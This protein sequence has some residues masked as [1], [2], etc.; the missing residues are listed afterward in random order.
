MAALSDPDRFDIWAEWMR[1][2]RETVAISKTDLRAA[3]NAI[4][5]EMDAISITLNNALPV[6]ARTGLTTSQKAALLSAVV[7]KRY[8]SGA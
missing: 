6:A 3:F 1:Q 2:N 7:A 5:D 4:D 8:S